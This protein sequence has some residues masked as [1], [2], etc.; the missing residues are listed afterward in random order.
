MIRK[1]LAMLLA[2][3]MLLGV[4]GCAV[5]GDIAGSVADAAVKVNTGIAADLLKG[6][7]FEL[8]RGVLG[9]DAPRGHVAQQRGH[10]LFVHG[11]SLPQIA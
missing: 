7:H 4:T 10:F 8:E 2:A 9:A 6:L 5:V 11:A 1:I 3:C